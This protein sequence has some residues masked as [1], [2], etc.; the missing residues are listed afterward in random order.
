MGSVASA[1]GPEQVCCLTSVPS[2]LD[3]RVVEDVRVRVYRRPAAFSN[4]TS[5]QAISLALAL[6]QI[7]LIERPQI[8]QL[9]MAYEGFIGLWLRRWLRLPFVIYAHGNEI[10]DAM[11]SE[12]QTPRLT[13]P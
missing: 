3:S 5:V 10:L 1:L 13:L 7:M 8:I 4:T 6:S 2:K 9:A 11:E 12:W